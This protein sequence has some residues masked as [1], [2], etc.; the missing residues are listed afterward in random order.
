MEIKGQGEKGREVKVG[1][2]K[3]RQEKAREGTWRGTRERG[4]EGEGKGLG[5]ERE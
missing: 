5:K 2:G 4:K 1:E 3:E